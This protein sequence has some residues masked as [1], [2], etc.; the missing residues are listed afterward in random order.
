M[1]EPISLYEARITDA[2][3][4]RDDAQEIVML[5][6]EHIRATLSEPISHWVLLPFQKPKIWGLNRAGLQGKCTL[7]NKGIFSMDRKLRLLASLSKSD[8]G[9]EIAPWHSG[10][11]PKREGW[12]VKILDVFDTNELRSRATA[13]PL[14]D[15][16]SVGYIELV[17]FI[18]S[19]CDIAEIIPT[20]RHNSFDWIISSHNFEHLPD[21]LKFL[22]GVEKILRPGG[23]LI[24]A[25]PDK[26]G[27]FDYF[28]ELTVIGDW[29]EA[30]LEQ[31][32]Q[33]APRQVFELRARTASRCVDSKNHT[34]SFSQKT[35]I[36]EIEILGD[37]KIAFE[38]WKKNTRQGYEDTHCSVFTPSSF[39]LLLLE[40][41][42][43]GLTSL[44]L[45][46]IVS[47]D[48]NEFFVRFRRPNGEPPEPITDLNRKRTELSRAIDRELSLIASM[49]FRNRL[50][51]RMRRAAT[52]IRRWN[53]HR[54]IRRNK[55][56]CS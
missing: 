44:E 39:E 31:R 3:L 30:H 10:L 16:E 33:P 51:M 12:N 55:L 45:E 54:K 36:E 41:S 46:T 15:E 26:R 19:A 50:I 18:G 8:S 7:V 9:I 53:H 25:I 1:E 6:F 35:P 47:T 49:S 24:M 34:I 5:H 38:Q 43:L 14:I 32:T 52:P 37:I 48:G 2:A 21:P 28:R 4:T 11:V 27:C 29:I 13:D 23:L 56:K 20:E 17:D 42:A 22:A 40:A